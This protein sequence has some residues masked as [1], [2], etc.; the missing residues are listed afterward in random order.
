MM[1]KIAPP[2]LVI[3][4]GMAS[5]GVASTLIC[6][7]AG[8]WWMTESL[9]LLSSLLDSSLDLIAS[10]L[11]LFALK[12]AQDPPDH[13]HRFGHGKAEALAGLGQVALILSSAFM[14]IME[15]LKDFYH[16]HALEQEQIG[17]IVCIISIILTG[18]LVLLQKWV[19]RKTKSLAI[20][21]DS[22]HYQMDII[23]N[24]LVIISLI[25]SKIWGFM[26]IDPLFAVGM[27]LYMMYGCKELFTEAAK[28][29]MDHE[30]PDNVRLSIE[31]IALSHPSV[32][33]I[34]DLRTRTS[35]NGIFIQFHMSIEGDMPLLQAHTITEEVEERLLKQ[36]PHAEIFIHQDPV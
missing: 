17:I 14:L 22:S 19:M 13:E 33:E 3:M 25:I 1:Q 12:L 7:K 16:P 6:I 11:N 5:V 29:L 20:K 30:L 35:G 18:G 27:S 28:Q 24:V 8:G 36:F 15:A 4:T 2:R 10:L 9:S 21:A 31:Q 23:T 26:W 32:P 34:H